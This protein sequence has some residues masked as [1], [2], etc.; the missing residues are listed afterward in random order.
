[1]ETKGLYRVVG[2]AGVAA[3]TAGCRLCGC[4]KVIEVIDQLPQAACIAAIEGKRQACEV[5]Q[6]RLVNFFGE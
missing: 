3:G 1:M 4:G 6:S 5:L 2:D